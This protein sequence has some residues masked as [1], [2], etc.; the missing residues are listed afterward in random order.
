MPPKHSK[1]SHKCAALNNNPGS[2]LELPPPRKRFHTDVTDAVCCSGWT[3]TGVGGVADQLHKAGEAVLAAGKKKQMK[4]E[5]L[6]D[7]REVVNL[8]APES[9]KRCTKKKNIILNDN[10]AELQRPLFVTPRPAFKVAKARER[11]EFQLPPSNAASQ[12]PKVKNT[13]ANGMKLIQHEREHQDQECAGGNRTAKSK[14]K[15]GKEGLH[16]DNNA[17]NWAGSDVVS[18][19]FGEDKEDVEDGDESSKEEGDKSNEDESD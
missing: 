9:P 15:K 5:D 7:T 1:K 17:D 12:A 19:V 4:A 14:G 6:K 3:G 18:W 11:F 13:L 10:D 16:N 8:M 2:D